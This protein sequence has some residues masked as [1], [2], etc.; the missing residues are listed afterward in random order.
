M[1]RPF[2]DSSIREFGQRIVSHEWSG[3]WMI[4]DLDEA[5]GNLKSLLSVQYDKCF[6]E[7]KERM[8]D[9]NKPWMT[10][11]FLKLMDQRRRAYDCGRMVQWRELY[12]KIKV[13]VKKAKQESARARHKKLATFDAYIVR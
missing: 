10:T 7:K 9:D 12:F 11:R 1:F 3:I 4:E 13:E 2:R 5:T 8:S 6:P